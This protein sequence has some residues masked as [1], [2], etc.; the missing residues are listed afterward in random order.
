MCCAAAANPAAAQTLPF[1][2]IETVP[3]QGWDDETPPAGGWQAIT[4]PDDW[5]ARLPGHD[6]IVWYR[7]SWTEPQDQPLQARDLFLRDLTMAGVVMLNG[8]EI[9][10]DPQLVEPLSRSWNLPRYWR[11]DEPLLRA[12]RNE[13]LIRVSGLAAFQPGLG[14][15]LL[16]TPEAVQPLYAN[17][18]LMRRSLQWVSIGITVVMAVLY[19]MLWA[20]RRSE[21][22]YGWFSLFSA[23]WVLFALNYLVTSPWPFETTGAYQRSNHV[24]MLGSVAAFYMFALSFCDIRRRWPRML[25]AV[26]VAACVLGL[27]LAPT[28]LV[29]EVRATAVLVALITHL[30]A[31]ALLVSHAVLSRRAEAV[32]LAA[33]LLLSVGID[34]HDTLVYMRVLPGNGYYL[35]LSSCATLLGISFALTW[36]M[37]QDMRLVEHFNQVL[38]KRVDEASHRLAEGMQRQHDAQ[39]EQTRL[40]ERLNLVRDLHDGLG[41]TIN[42]HIHALQGEETDSRRDP[43]L[44]ALREVN[45]DLRLIIENSAFDDSEDLGERIAPL[46]HR[47][48]RLLEAAGIECRWQLEG[49]Q[50]CRLSSRRALDF[51][52]VLQ[53]ALA[54]V[55]KHSSARQ[56]LVRIAAQRGELQLEVQD[57]GRGFTPEAAN[58]PSPVPGMG[59]ASMRSRARRLGGE[60]HIDSRADGTRLRL[61][62]PLAARPVA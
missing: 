59:L 26:P 15:V 35:A 11:L 10:H 23:L 9:A 36:R 25:M 42:S 27:I 51:L 57:D 46:R 14:E 20:L 58:N 31:C 4:L 22:T 43:G 52:R 32:V 49:L 2:R 40:A 28:N 21:V 34:V 37:V 13:L 19:G 61:R 17:E 7:L 18:L 50:G 29:A 16:G 8:S 24:F 60:L 44:W 1:D 41:M 5:S 47:S 53:E 38:Q 39:L 33:C 56:V 45:D 3:G 48:M 55:V 54:N 6:G 12:G 30:A 62:C